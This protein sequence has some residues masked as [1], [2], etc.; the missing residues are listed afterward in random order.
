MQL[1]AASLCAAKRRFGRLA[2]DR[3]G[4]SLIE[5]AISLPVLLTLGM[6]G[7]ELANMA[8]TNMQ[9]S[10][11]AMAVADNA[12]RLGQTDNSAIT[13]TIY[14]TDI[15][16]VMTGAMKQGASISLQA[17]GRV[18]LSSL[19]KSATGR[20]YIHWQKCRGSLGQN[21]V[22]GGAGYGLT[23]TAFTGLGKSGSISANANSAVMF[24]EVYYSYKPLFGTMFVNN[25]K[26]SQEAA[27][28]IR[29]DRN[30]T[31]GVPNTPTGSSECS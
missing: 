9:V 8:T 31:A 30:L 6:Y 2:G 13:P 5:F 20:Q 14:N 17:N 19:E 10:Q 23:G 27:F 24:V 15:D 26:F 11:V 29:D 3:S 1:I 7:I 21:S 18:I 22:Y 16:S 28:I 25:V 12:S 4:N